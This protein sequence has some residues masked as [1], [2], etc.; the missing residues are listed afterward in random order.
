M[1]VIMPGTAATF[2]RRSAMISS[3]E[4]LRSLARLH[5]REDECLIAA[6]DERTDRIDFR[7]C[8]DDVGDGAVMLRHVL[9]RDVLRAHRHREHEAAVLAGDEAAWA[10]W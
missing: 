9:E 10:S 1:N 4:C 7:M 2:G 8:A 3:T 5:A 6:H